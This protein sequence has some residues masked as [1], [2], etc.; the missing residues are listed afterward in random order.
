M[1]ELRS[2]SR[3][4]CETLLSSVPV[5]RLVF[6]EGAL[7]AIRPVNFLYRGGEIIVRTTR[8]GAM[9]RLNGEVVAFE[10]DDV[11]PEARMG[12][13]VVAVGWVEPVTDI[14]EVVML[15]DPRRRPWPLGE[16]PHYLRIHV[17]ILTGRQLALAGA[18][19]A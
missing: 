17:E 12:W 18:Q 8:H 6:S 16:R 9:S 3:A 4:E 5:G 2:L 11:D 7:P 14:D 1:K 19:P 13:S 10:A 15:T